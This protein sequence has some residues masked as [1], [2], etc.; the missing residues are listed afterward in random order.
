VRYL[1]DRG[2]I[3]EE[4]EVIKEDVSFALPRELL[5]TVATTAPTA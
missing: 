5:A 4:L 3:T 2:A 1:E